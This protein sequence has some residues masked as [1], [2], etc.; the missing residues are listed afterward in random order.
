MPP[1]LMSQTGKGK[2]NTPGRGDTAELDCGNA[3]RV[4]VFQ[5][6]AAYRKYVTF[7]PMVT[8]G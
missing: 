3:W 2:K 8:T 6:P 4:R 1:E 7:Y 5:H